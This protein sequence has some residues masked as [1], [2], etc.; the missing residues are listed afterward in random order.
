MPVSWPPHPWP[1]AIF[2][3]VD[4]KSTAFLV[5]IHCYN[6]E[7]DLT[8]LLHPK[9][10]QLKVNENWNWG[11]GGGMALCVEQIPVATLCNGCICCF[12]VFLIERYWASHQFEPEPTEPQ[13]RFIALL[14]SSVF[15]KYIRM[16]TQPLLERNIFLPGLVQTV[17]TVWCFMTVNN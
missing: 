6:N 16:V 5:D 3:D 17:C 2:N 7:A 8:V 15:V 11:K 12:D 4:I 14:S 1:G 10:K 13:M 9:R